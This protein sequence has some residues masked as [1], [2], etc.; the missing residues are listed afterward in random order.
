MS[1]YE[2]CEMQYTKNTRVSYYIWLY[3]AACQP[4]CFSGFS[5]GPQPSERYVTY[6]TLCHANI[7]K[8]N[9]E[10]TFVSSFEVVCF[11]CMHVA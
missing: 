3:F 9:R 8:A 2:V 4:A 6:V 10:H 11:S 1:Q 7:H 5:D